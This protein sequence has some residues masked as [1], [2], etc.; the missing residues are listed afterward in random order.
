MKNSQPRGPHKKWAVAL[1]EILDELAWTR[2]ETC[3]QLQVTS[4]WLKKALKGYELDGGYRIP[5]QR[6]LERKWEEFRKDNPQYRAIEWPP[7]TENISSQPAAATPES[8]F[9]DDNYANA[10][11]SRYGYIALENLGATETRYQA[12]KLTSI[13]VPQ[14]VRLSQEVLPTVLECSKEHLR[15]LK[16]LESQVENPVLSDADI[17]RQRYVKEDASSVLSVIADD[18]VNQKIVFLGSLGAGKSSLIQFLALRWAEADKQEK[19]HH[20]FPLII[21][22][23]YYADARHS[24]C[25]FKGFEEFLCQAPSLTWRF[26]AESLKKILLA[27]NVAVFFDGLDDVYDNALYEEVG[28]SIVRFA[29][30]YPN[31]QIIVTS[32]LP[33]YREV[34]LRRAGFN[35][36]ILE[37]FDDRQIFKFIGDWFCKL[38]PQNNKNESAKKADVF[39]KVI[40]GSDTLRELARSPFFL[41]IMLYLGHDDKSPRNRADLLGQ[42]SLTLLKRWKVDKALRADPDLAQDATALG[43]REKQTILRDIVRTM[44]TA[45]DF[46]TNIIS[47][48]EIETSIVRSIKDIVRANP[49]SVARAMIKQLRERN[50]I[51]RLDGDSHYAF[52]HPAFMEYYSAEDFHYRLHSKQIDEKYLRNRFRNWIVKLHTANETLSFFCGIAE[53]GVAGRLLE[54]LSALCDKKESGQ[55]NALLIAECVLEIKGRNRVS[56]KLLKQIK[57]ALK[58]LSCYTLTPQEIRAGFVSNVKRLR[59]SVKVIRYLSVLFEGDDEVAKHLRKIIL[60]NKRYYGESDAVYALIRGW[61]NH[62]KI[63]DWLQSMIENKNSREVRY[64]L[65]IQLAAHWTDSRTLTYLKQQCSAM[66]EDRQGWGF[67]I[68]SI[69]NRWKQDN[70]TKPWLKK[71]F[72]STPYPD[73]KAFII[74]SIATNYKHDKDVLPWLEDIV[75]THRDW[76]ARVTAIYYIASLHEQQLDTIN[77]LIETLRSDKDIR[78]RSEAWN[79]IE[80]EYME[81][82][83]VQSL[84]SYLLQNDNNPKVRSWALHGLINIKGGNPKLLNTLESIIKSDSDVGIRRQAVEAL[85]QRFEHKSKY[86]RTLKAIKGKSR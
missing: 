85:T 42:C 27:G 20:K 17:L 10:I 84:L 61:K 76:E 71:L 54:Y 62:P 74:E 77:I 7:F 2:D 9:D 60:G 30:E 13:Y 49:L 45:S 21:E 47:F 16:F 22:L 78:V 3:T 64:A 19:P 83:K 52:V 50:G 12:L 55:D 34:G 40:F 36:Y 81:N 70:A 33:G 39:R 23:K 53:P 1:R 15:N 28:A 44:G 75:R 69:A 63:R 66:N 35:H 48:S 73:I 31:I 68:S 41:T 51:L 65:I 79:I 80:R 86:E 24:G 72:N 38:L 67:A 29:I 5:F 59:T 6:R 25:V 46:P 37:D 11:R 14:R 56:G 82:S 43:I 26:T 8:T 4:A 18:D 57:P 32:R 58:A